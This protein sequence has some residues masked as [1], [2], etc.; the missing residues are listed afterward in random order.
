MRNG[1]GAI[2]MLFGIDLIVVVCLF[3]YGLWTAAGCPGEAWCFLN[4]AAEFVTFFGDF[5]FVVDMDEAAIF[6]GVWAL[7][8]G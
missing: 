5:F 7:Y 2:C 8:S 1:L 6:T 3:W 4:P